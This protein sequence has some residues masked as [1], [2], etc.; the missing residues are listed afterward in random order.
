MRR[1][2]LISTLVGVAITGSVAVY[3]LLQLAP[4][5]Y[6]PTL[7][8]YKSATCGCCKKWVDHLRQNG[9]EVKAINRNDLPEIKAQHGINKSIAACHTALID[10]YVVEG[11][12]PA[13]AIRRLL[14]ERPEVEGIAVPGMPL[15]SPGMESRDPQPYSILTFDEKGATAV[16]EVR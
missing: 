12:V 11:H 14:R 9:F 5:T 1:S 2:S 10:G 3:W 7:T 6:G 8:V 4:D 15:G 16:Y 13:D